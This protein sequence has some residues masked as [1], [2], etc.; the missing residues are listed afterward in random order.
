[1]RPDFGST[2]P[3]SNW[4]ALRLTNTSARRPRVVS[5]CECECLMDDVGR[6][7]GAKVAAQADGDGKT[8]II[9]SGRGDRQTN[10]SSECDWRR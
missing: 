2:S 7:L 5:V 8:I 9:E 6:P 1:M 10:T 3:A 4:P